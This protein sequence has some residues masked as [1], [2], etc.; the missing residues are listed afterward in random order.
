MLIVAIV[1][2]MQKAM[3]GE[4]FSCIPYWRMVDRMRMGIYT[5]LKG[6]GS[7]RLLPNVHPWWRGGVQGR[8][9]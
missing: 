7:I 5:L 3:P 6:D 1:V 9:R 2:Q 4:V 8:G